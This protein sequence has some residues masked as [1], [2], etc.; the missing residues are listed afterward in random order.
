MCRCRHLADFIEQQ[1][2]AVRQFE[3]ANAPLGRPRESPAFVAKNLAFHQGLRD[4][5]TID[6]YKRSVRAR[7]ELVQ[8]PRH[9]LLARPRLS[10]DQY[11]SRTR[12]RHLHDAH[13]LL[14]LL[15][16]PDQ[17]TQSPSFTK[18]PLQHR[19]LPRIPRLA[20]RPVQQGPQHRPLQWFFDVPERSGLDR[21]HRPLFAAFAGN[22]D[23]R[24]IVEF[25]PKLL[26]QVQP[27]HPGQF[28]VGN[29]RVRL[30][31][32]K[33]CQRFFRRS[34]AHHVAAP[35][36]QELFVALA[37]VVFIFDNQHAVLPL[38][39]FDGP[40]RRPRFFPHGFSASLRHALN[41]WSTDYRAGHF[42]SSNLLAPCQVF[43]PART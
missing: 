27:I 5:R 43:W 29:Q 34:H 22:D 41:E 4:C 20:Q 14:H 12:R 2:A 15:R 23:G 28:H 8:R 16:R 10:R 39:H 31:T 26:Q 40:H 35:P 6:G 19:E 21:R 11:R 30:V 25:R 36:L 9:N 42:D 24:H 1:R 37:R 38:H 32:R 7:R 13:H 18:L 33:F 17:V 3:A